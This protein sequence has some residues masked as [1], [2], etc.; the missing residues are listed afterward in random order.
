MRKHDIQFSLPVSI[1]KEDKAFVAYSPALDISTVGDSFEEA[2]DRFDQAV[3]LFFEE[4][5]EA[6]TIDQVLS[7]LGW[8]RINK[9]YQPPVVVANQT[10]NFCFPTP[11]N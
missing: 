7:D 5:I 11:I 10:Q 3:K 9:K 2:K 6:G 1:L 8:Q 4:I